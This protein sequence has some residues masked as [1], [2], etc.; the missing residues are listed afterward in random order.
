[1]PL[2]DNVAM[3]VSLST[4]GVSTGRDKFPVMSARSL[5]SWYLSVSGAGAMFDFALLRV[6]TFG[7]GLLAA[8]G[9]SAALFSMLT[10]LVIY[11]QGVTNV[12]GPYTL[13]ALLPM[14]E[15]GTALTAFLNGIGFFPV[16]QTI[17]GSA[18]MEPA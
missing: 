1:M 3:P 17:S 11:L 2:V 6:P 9:I 5:P 14:L 16:W 18:P 8:W 4:F 15:P 13:G 10:F 12:W 7:G